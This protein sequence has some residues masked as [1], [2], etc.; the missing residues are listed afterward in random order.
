M[1]YENVLKK[2]NNFNFKVQQLGLV[3]HDNP[4]DHKIFINDVKRIAF[5]NQVKSLSRQFKTKNPIPSFEKADAKKKI[6]HDLST[7]R[8]GII[9]CGDLYLGLNNVIK[10]LINVLEQS[11]GVETIFGIRDR[12]KGL[13]KQSQHQP[14]RL[15]ASNINQIHKQGGTILGLS[16]GNQDPEE[17]VSELQA[18]NINILF[19]MGSDRTLKGAQAIANTANQRN[20]NIS[21]VGVSKTIDNELGLVE[22]TFGFETSVQIVADIIS[23]AYSE[24]EGAENGIGIIKLMGRDSGFITAKASLA[25]SVVDFCLIPETPFQIVRPDSIWEYLIGGDLA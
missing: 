4:S 14:I 6:F 10:G 11:Y 1:A 8:V 3:Q 24:A 5:S 25:N 16:R 23:S 13:T 19:C 17:K 18:G 22:K 20:A 9:T 15:T 2:P 21:I 7:T 12:Y